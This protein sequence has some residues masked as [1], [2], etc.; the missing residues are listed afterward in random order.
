MSITVDTTTNWPTASL[1][2]F[3]I[4]TTEIVNG[5]E[6]R[7][8]GSY[9]VFRGIVTSATTIGSLTKLYGTAQD[10]AS[11]ATT[12]VYI[13]VSSYWNNYL[14][15]GLLVDHL[16]AGYHKSL[17]DTNGNEWLE[18]GVTAS[19]VNQVKVTNAAIGNAPEISAS[20]DDTNID[21]KISPKGT[22]KI[23]QTKRADG[24]V[25]GL[26]APATVTCNGNRSYSVVI[27]ATD[28]TDRLSP[29]MRLRFT[30]TVTA[31]T[32]CTD[33]ESGS[34][35]YY[36]KSSPS[37]MTFTDDFVVSA[38][39]KLESY[40]AMSIASRYN[41]T[42]GW[43]FNIQSTGQ[44]RLNGFKAGAANFSYVE[45]YQSVP[46]GKWVHITAQLDMSAFTATTTT[47]YVMFDCVDIPASVTRGG[48]NPT[49]LTQAGNLEIGG[50]NGGLQP[51]D[52]KLAQVAIYSAKVTQANVKATIS[53]TLSG[54]ETSLISAYSFNNTINDLNANANNLTAQNSAVATNSD[55]PFSQGATGTT[56][57][58]IITAVAFSTDTTI[59]V[60]VPENGAIPTSGGV[61]A[62]AYST[63]KAPFGMPVDE[64]KWTIRT[65]LLTTN[66]TTSNATY[67]SFLS[68]GYAIT[69]P[70]G[71]WKV[72]ILA[73]TYNSN[74]TQVVF[75][76]APSTASIT[77]T[78]SSAGFALSQKAFSNGSPSAAAAFLSAYIYEDDLLATA[79][80]YTLYSLGATT[81]A[82]IQGSIQQNY[83]FARLNSL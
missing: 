68:G 81:A 31:P 5:L 58:G 45:S 20:G 2:I 46:L 78:T 10:Y 34:S 67:G 40:A 3:A 59:T 37:G 32:K 70:V 39:V 77:G 63:Q 24:W 42:S 8:D 52:G 9:N 33:L 13:I 64:A 15:D 65:L 43:D 55:T 6:T 79:T 17:S 53:Q 66:A 83:L 62:M 12:R 44:V 26:T 74:T 28:Y 57:Y 60:Q 35:N 4:D 38:W 25:T 16:A 23:E 49:D 76:L 75:N 41:G 27:S 51:F 14:V 21:L 1:V 18:R 29:G 22:G 69:V 11:G 56:E 36:S 47:S 80:V 48:T 71:P 54:S 73:N 7:V 72:G 61:S 82:N 50:R 19:A 30:R